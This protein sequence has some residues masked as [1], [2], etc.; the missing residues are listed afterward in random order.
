MKTGITDTSLSITLPQRLCR[1]LCENLKHFSC[2]ATI[3]LS[4]HKVPCTLPSTYNILV[5]CSL[6][7]IKRVS[8]AVSDTFIKVSEPLTYSQISSS[9]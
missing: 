3:F 8:G 4:P 1:E 5:P 2:T 7:M 9:I 6:Q